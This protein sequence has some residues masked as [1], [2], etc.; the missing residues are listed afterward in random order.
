[1]TLKYQLDTLDGLDDAA[2]KLYT[3]KDGKFVLTVEGLPQQD[4]TLA[5]RLAKLE[6]NNADLLKEK[7]EAKAAAEKAALDAA[8]KGGDVEALEKSW[9]DKLA[10]REAEL[11]GQLNQY[12]QMVS[13]L[14]V[15]AT[16]STLA[17]E[18]FGANAEL[19]MPHLNRR[20][21]TEIVDGAP[22][23]R[24]L[25]AD[26]KPT[27]LTVE[28]LKKEIQTAPK[29][30]AFVVGSKATGPGGHGKPGSTGAT[31]MTR[32]AF[33]QLPGDQK[34]KLSSEGLTLV[35]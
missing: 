6:A 34:M 29:F 19:M 5:D 28:D 11:T 33:E 22:K 2:K 20:M 27:A 18:L 25:D 32:T 30:A 9:S 4:N 35:D 7:R 10:A 14:T 13:G 16:A 21:T 15:G 23:V 3:E 1:M 26:G 12:Q 31:T 17:A 8:K 24:V